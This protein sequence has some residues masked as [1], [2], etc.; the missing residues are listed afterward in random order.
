MLTMCVTTAKMTTR[1]RSETI[2]VDAERCLRE[3]AK[4]EDKILYLRVIRA[5][6][7]SIWPVGQGR[8]NPAWRGGDVP[9]DIS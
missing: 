6:L 1:T 5:I 4:S 9:S 2:G 3:E 8:G 7:R